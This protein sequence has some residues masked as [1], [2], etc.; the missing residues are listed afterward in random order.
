MPEPVGSL[1]IAS[2]NAR[3][4]SN[5]HLGTGHLNVVMTGM[6]NG[7][8]YIN[9]SIDLSAQCLIP[10][11]RHA[12]SRKLPKHPKNVLKMVCRI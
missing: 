9:S 1:K 8:F 7:K 4:R 3:C 12:G 10:N 5:W 11:K 6:G 2:T